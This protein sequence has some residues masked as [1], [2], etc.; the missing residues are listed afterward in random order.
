[1]ASYQA[2]GRGVRKTDKGLEIKVELMNAETAQ[3]VRFQTYEGPSLPAI[4]QQVKAD[5]DLLV[6]SETDAALSAAVVGVLLATSQP[7]EA[8]PPVEALSADAPAA[9]AASEPVAGS[10]AGGVK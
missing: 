2:I 5:L 3:T 7:A 8:I 6:T 4:Q 9:V 1:M 10:D